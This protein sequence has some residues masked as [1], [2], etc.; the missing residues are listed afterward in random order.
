MRILNVS[1][2]GVP[3]PSY[4]PRFYDRFPD[5]IH[6]DYKA[7]Y[8]AILHDHFAWAMP[9]NHAMG[10]FGY[11]VW[12]VDRGI[13]AMQRAW[14]RENGHSR[15]ALSRDDIVIA[16][17]KAFSPDILFYDLSDRQLL[18]R[19]RTEV[20]SI[21]AVFGWV[22]SPM[23]LGK[24]WGLMDVLLTCAPES[25]DRLQ[26]MGVR[27]VHVNHSFNPEITGRLHPSVA[28]I[29]ASFIGSVVRRN[30]FHL[31]REEL[32]LRF[33]DKVPLQIY[34]PSLHVTGR[35]YLK[36][37][38]AAISYGTIGGLKRARVLPRLRWLPIVQRAERIASP[39]R[40]PINRRLA[41]GMLPAVFG[42]EYFQVLKDSRIT[43]NVHADTSPVYASNMRLFEATGVGSCLLTD[44]KK[45]IG[46]LYQPDAEVVVYRSAE[47]AV[48]KARWLSEHPLEGEEIAVA[49]A[50]RTL[51]S[52]TFHHRAA[53]IDDIIRD[54]LASHARSGLNN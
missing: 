36:A 27:A 54:E 48:E 3:Y 10:P 20:Q 14:A 37:A 12:N 18:R 41:K 51:A 43:L 28:R 6:G 25:V 39:P 26:R 33:R 35:D 44:W 49:G 30:E 32:L 19:L 34:S 24:A 23:T 13:A 8:D 29:E 47:E 17:A 40:L 15:S 22:G 21:R 46:E 31:G 7:H 38:V 2:V 16:Q 4:L 42:L 45:N 53:Q 1:D 11:E 9:F 52:H 50:R 5:L